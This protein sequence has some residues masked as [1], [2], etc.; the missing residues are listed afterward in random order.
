MLK[1][2]SSGKL[3]LVRGFVVLMEKK[4]I[5]DPR[6]KEFGFHNFGRQRAFVKT[7]QFKP[8][9]C[10]EVGCG[11]N[12]IFTILYLFQIVLGGILMVSRNV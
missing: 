2:H 12:E 1:Q 4:K 6:R 3:L 10:S 8:S 7:E 9:V 11:K 5:E